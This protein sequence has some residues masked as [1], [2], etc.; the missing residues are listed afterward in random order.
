MDFEFF[1]QNSNLIFKS[2]LLTNFI[3]KNIAGNK[4][5]NNWK[6]FTIINLPL[7]PKSKKLVS[8]DAVFCGFKCT[9]S[10][11]SY[12]GNKPY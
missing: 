10:F 3:K 8:F 7:S 12:L 11:L 2:K 4:A 5:K 6:G 1:L 9:L